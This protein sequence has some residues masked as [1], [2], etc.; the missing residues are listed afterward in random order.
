MVDL[1][2]LRPPAPRREGRSM[3]FRRRPHDL[4]GDAALARS[5]ISTMPTKTPTAEPAARHTG[6]AELIAFQRSAGNAAV[7]R[8][9]HQSSTAVLSAHRSVQRAD[10]DSTGVAEA[11]GR[12]TLRQGSIGA[13]VVDAQARI[14]GIGT[15][16]RLVVDGIFGPKTRSGVAAYQQNHGLLADGVIGPRTWRALDTTG[17]APND[18][19]ACTCTVQDEEA[20]VLET[21]SD[22]VLTSPDADQVPAV[23]AITLQADDEKPKDTPVGTPVPSTCSSDAKACFSLSKRR[24]WLL[25]PNKVVVLEVA[26]LGGRKGHPTPRGKFTV[27]S[28]DKD[29][30]SSL[31]K[32]PKTGKPAPMPFYVNFAP[33]VGFHVGSLSTESHGCVHLSASAA[34]SFFNHLNKGDRVDVVP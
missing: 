18:P 12:P 13:D 27:I 6:T 32:D 31:Y 14:N 2:S 9:V 4:E 7:T 10:Q 28:K 19:L 3:M 33:A 11:T 1:L 30:H 23:Q 34:A 16:P 15:S 20:D 25:K 24:A 29:H 17:P 8:L 26:A 22:A 5:L 21:T